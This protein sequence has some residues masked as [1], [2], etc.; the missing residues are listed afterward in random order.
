VPA[1]LSG[2]MSL[3]GTMGALAG[4]V[5][6]AAVTGSLID[7]WAPRRL[8]ALAMAGFGATLLDSLLGATVQTRRQ[9][10]VCGQASEC[11]LHCGRPTVRLRGVFSNSGVNLVSAAVAGWLGWLSFS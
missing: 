8:F 3:K 6:L 2:G 9:C 10:R 4:A 5:A 1:G 11:A 7:P